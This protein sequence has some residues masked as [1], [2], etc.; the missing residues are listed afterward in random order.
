MGGY[1]LGA[2][3]VRYFSHA[4]AAPAQVISQVSSAMRA[5]IYNG[6]DQLSFST[7]HRHDGKPGKVG[8]RAQLAAQLS[9]QDAPGS[10]IDFSLAPVLTSISPLSNKSN[11][12]EN[13]AF[14]QALSADFGA[15]MGSLT[16]VYSDIKRLASLGDLPVSLA[17]NGL[18]L[19]VKFPGCDAE[20]VESICTE[21]DIRRGIIREDDRFAFSHLAPGVAPFWADNLAP[22]TPHSI[23]TQ[24]NDGFSTPS[25]VSSHGDREMEVVS[26]IAPGLGLG[27]DVETAS[28]H[29]TPTDGSG[30]QADD[31]QA[32]YYFR[33]ISEGSEIPDS[34]SYLGSSEAG[35]ELARERRREMEQVLVIGD[36]DV[37]GIRQFL[38]EIDEGV[39]DG[40]R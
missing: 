36:E 34:P 9:S 22:D 14:L 10:Y 35:S 27:S 26:P 17:E 5:F 28:A 8:V 37:R 4:P 19:R 3:G 32:S 29:W 16:A 11:T 20:Y 33:A 6:K 24:S 31:T 30:S 21:L 38:E 40:W 13:T 23:S 39:R 2:P 25:L 12:L 18:V 1:S 15:M 7:Y